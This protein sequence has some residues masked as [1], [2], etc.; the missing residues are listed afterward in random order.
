MLYSSTSEKIFEIGDKFYL[1]DLSFVEVHSKFGDR[2][3]NTFFDGGRFIKDEL[4]KGH[5]F[6]VVSDPYK[7][8]YT[9]EWYDN[10]GGKYNSDLLSYTRDEY[11]V[12]VMICE[13]EDTPILSILNNKEGVIEDYHKYK[14]IIDLYNFECLG[15]VL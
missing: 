6:I 3:I 12:D 4:L 11:R 13:C 10:S 1:V 5:P 8:E 14:N 2:S 15:G 9:G 7:V